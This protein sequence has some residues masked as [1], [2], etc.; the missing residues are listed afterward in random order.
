MDIFKFKKCVEFR[1]R[2]D[3]FKNGT[4]SWPVI[5]DH[6]RNKVNNVNLT[7]FFSTSSAAHALLWFS[8]HEGFKESKRLHSD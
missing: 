8:V 6:H 3:V 4:S 7:I 2:C 1:N 5:K